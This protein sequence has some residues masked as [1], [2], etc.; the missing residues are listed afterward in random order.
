MWCERGM[1]ITRRDRPRVRGR[2]SIV[3]FIS[4][5]G[6][7]R[8]LVAVIFCLEV[9]LAGCALRSGGRP[10]GNQRGERLA[11]ERGRLIE[12][13]DPMA[14]TKSYIVISDLLLSF[15]TDAAGERAHDDLRGLLD[16]YTQT[17]RAARET[18]VTSK[19]PP[20]GRP[21]GHIDLERALGRQLTTLDDFRAKFDA[22][23]P[24]TLDLARQL[25]ASIRQEMSDMLSRVED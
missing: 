7:L 8:K 12:T 4:T 22:T 18:I 13:T 14:R 16:E 17:I 23:D 5:E 10:S 19:R 9:C 1:A 15:A 24:E 20:D 11:L 21:Q 2:G 6:L 3:T 25:A